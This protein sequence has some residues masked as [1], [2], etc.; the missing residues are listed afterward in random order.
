M[1]LSQLYYFRKL[2]QLEHYT[3]AA[4]EL[5]ISQPSLSASIASLEE[6]LNVKLFQKS[7]R[8]VHLTDVGR[9]FYEIVCRCLNILE[10]GIENLQS[11]DD[12]EEVIIDLVCEASLLLD[13]V[14]KLLAAFQTYDDSIKFR[15]HCDN[16][17]GIMAGVRSG[18][19]SFG[20]SLDQHYDPDLDFMQFSLPDTAPQETQLLSKNC[21]LL[22]VLSVTDE[23]ADSKHLFFIYSKMRYFP[24]TEQKFL[25]FIRDH[26]A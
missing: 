7:G 10:A 26:S 25:S 6:E 4:Q 5:Y 24:D 20:I 22:S 21:N 16:L 15:L 9:Q 3:K 12:Q 14:P 17:A 19:Y 18:K 2:A 23:R 8:N 1:T 11:Q 13:F